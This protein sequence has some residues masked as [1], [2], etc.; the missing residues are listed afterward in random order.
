MYRICCRTLSVMIGPNRYPG[1][2]VR[3][4]CIQNNEILYVSYTKFLHYF[5]DKY[6]IQLPPKHV[7][8]LRLWCGLWMPN[9]AKQVTHSSGACAPGPCWRQGLRMPSMTCKLDLTSRQA[10]QT[11]PVCSTHSDS[12]ALYS[13]PLAPVSSLLIDP[14]AAV[15]IMWIRVSAKTRVSAAEQC[16]KTYEFWWRYGEWRQGLP[17]GSGWLGGV[18][19]S[20]SD[21]RS[22]GPGLDSRPVHRQATTLGKLLTPMCL[23]H[24]AV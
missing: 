19:V 3:K 20:V 21:S 12:S 6:A 8:I 15:N 23:C 14:P 22:R 4:L 7:N 18:A 17:M 24:Q 9:T 11:S 10:G 2:E 1:L 13:A 5:F 16:L